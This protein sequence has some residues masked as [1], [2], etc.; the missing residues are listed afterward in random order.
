MD[1]PTTSDHWVSPL[2]EIELAVQ[3]RAKSLAVDS[4]GADAGVILKRLVDDELARWHQDYRKGIRP[5]DIAEPEVAAERAMR[6]LTGY[7]P[8]QPLLDDPDVWDV[9]IKPSSTWASS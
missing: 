7:G 2:V 1:T 3:E 4:S 6:N 8:L 9:M 5:F